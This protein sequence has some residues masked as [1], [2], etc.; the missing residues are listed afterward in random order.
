M[1]LACDLHIHSALSPCADDD[2]SPA[3]IVA[4]AALKGLDVIA[5]TDHNS[6]RNVRAAMQAAALVEGPPL[7]VP[8]VEVQ[9]REE[10]HILCYFPG[11]DACEA[12]EAQLAPTLLPLPNNKQIMGNQLVMDARGNVTDEVP[13]TLLQSSAWDIEDVCAICARLGGA[14]LPAHVNRGSCSLLVMLGF[15]PER[16]RFAACEVVP[17]APLQAPLPAG[18][19]VLHASDAHNLGALSEREFF[20]DLPQKS[21]PAL[22]QWLRGEI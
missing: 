20:L 19:R 4:M 10:V 21:T 5:L 15:F 14:A 6:G 16:P 22:L 9:S 13:Y 1:N 18:I 3:N 17:G 2:M 12:F 7:V 8:G 11:V